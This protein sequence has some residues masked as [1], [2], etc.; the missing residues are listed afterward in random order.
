MTA[1]T[2]KDCPERSRRIDA[3]KDDC[4]KDISVAPKTIAAISKR[5]RKD[6]EARARRKS[7][8]RPKAITHGLLQ[9]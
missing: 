4:L 6:L 8:R 2:S 5:A 1:V 9:L 7:K 3:S